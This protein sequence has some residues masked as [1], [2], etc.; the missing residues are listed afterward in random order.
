MSY[1]DYYWQ[2][3]E[4][5]NEAVSQTSPWYKYLCEY[6][7]VSLDE[8]IKLGTRSSGR[9]PSLPGSRTCEPVS[10][11]THEDIWAMRDRTTQEDIFQFYI[12][13]GAWSTF[14]QTVRHADPSCKG[15]HS[16][17]QQLAVVVDKRKDDEINVCE[18]GSGIAPYA[19][20][21]LESTKLNN[22]LNLYISDVD[23]SEHFLYSSWMLNR[24]VE[25]NGSNATINPVPVKHDSL[26]S[27]DKQLDL[28]VCFEVMEHVA[29]PV[30]AL[31]NLIDHMN[32]GC[33]YI[34]NFIK[35]DHDDDEDP[36]PDLESAKL[37]REKYYEILNEKFELLTN[38]PP[39]THPNETRIWAKK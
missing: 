34:E 9:K 1:N 28:V 12:D 39:N 2:M 21:L 10:G 24:V 22:K 18:Y 35:H 23:G 11:M 6:Y 13:Q 8:A 17:V 16:V 5:I 36:G 26:P 19:R 33:H 30:A 31:N 14:R 29:S 38:N 25:D 4:G 3:S 27:Y 20:V 32:L 37:E 7:G 15:M